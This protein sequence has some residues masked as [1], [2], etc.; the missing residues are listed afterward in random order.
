MN[1]LV[2]GGAG[3][4]G[5]HTCIALRAAGHEVVVVDNLCNSHPRAIERVEA[6]T[7]AQVPFYE[8]D[9]RD[10]EGLRAVFEAH[11]VDA[12]IHFAGLKAVGESVSQP[13]RYYDNNLNSTLCLIE[14]MS[15]HQVHQ[16][17]FSSSATVYGEAGERPVTEDAPV[18]GA[19]NPYGQTKLMIEQI[20]RDLHIS[21]PDLWKIV[22]LRYFNPV[23]AHESGLIGEDP[24]GT[25]SNLL[26]YVTQVACGR[27]EQLTVFGDDYPTPDGTP[28][29]DYIHVEDLAAGHVHALKGLEAPGWA[30]YNLGTGKGQSVLEVLSAF[31]RATGQEI[32]YRVG[33]RR[34][35]DLVFSCADPGRAQKTLGWRATHTFE[36][37]C[38]DAWRW[39]QK[40]PTGYRDA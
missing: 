4:I 1:V 31:T 3:Y 6:I 38:R 16:L 19:T 10:R 27:L 34:P 12:V 5:T 11:T 24:S 20:T 22:V 15:R 32:P 37:A 7:G 18:G 39:Q 28:V 21:A 23:G 25:P 30:A 33:P 36:D 14:E 40:N 9:L 2:T 29:R 8:I 26:P 17:I 13:L 35:G